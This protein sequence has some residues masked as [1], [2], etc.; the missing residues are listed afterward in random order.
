M[1]EVMAPIAAP[2]KVADLQEQPGGRGS[3][4]KGAQMDFVRLFLFF[5]RKKYCHNGGMG[6]VPNYLAAFN[7]AH[8]TPAKSVLSRRSSSCSG[9]CGSRRRAIGQRGF[10]PFEP[11]SNLPKLRRR[12]A[13][14]AKRL[15]AA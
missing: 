2:P 1:I 14:T 8:L 15:L 5:S 11:L 10:D 7:R 9:S 12:T 3:R 4:P 13:G 6:L